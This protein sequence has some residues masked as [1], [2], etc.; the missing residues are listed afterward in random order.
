M[1]TLIRA[2]RKYARRRRSLRRLAAPVARASS[3][4]VST[5][6]A[7]LAMMMM[8]MMMIWLLLAS[9]E[10][11]WE[12]PIW[13]GVWPHLDPMDSVC[14]RTTSM[15]SNVLRKYGPHGEL[16][17]FLLQKEQAIA[18]SNETF[19]PVI[20][21]GIRFSCFS[22][23]VREKCALIALQVMSEAAMGG[24]GLQVPE[25]GEEWKVGCQNSPMWESKGEAWS[26]DESVSSSGSREG[27]VRNDALHVV[28]LHGSG[29]KIS[30]YLQGWELAKV[31]LSCHMAL[32]M[33]CQEMNEVW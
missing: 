28:G 5:T 27:I 23:D 17:F 13:E 19:S 26:E 33:L 29:D 1:A 16:F 20:N 22:A 9:S 4:D 7:I 18:P 6:E 11:L 25:L 15:E 14:L 3:V 24:D 30:L 21:P 10:G 2:Y 32:D 31:A 12:K 8:M